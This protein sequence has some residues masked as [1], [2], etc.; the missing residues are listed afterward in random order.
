MACGLADRPCICFHPV[1]TTAHHLMLDVV[2]ENGI[3][4]LPTFLPSPSPPPNTQLR[5]SSSNLMCPLRHP[6]RLPLESHILQQLEINLLRQSPRRS[7]RLYRLAQRKLAAHK[8]ASLL[9]ELT[10]PLSPIRSPG[11]WHSAKEGI[12][13]DEIEG[14]CGAGEGCVK[15]TRSEGCGATD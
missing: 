8:N 1:L 14:G 15:V 12:V 5:P 10:H 6:P 4:I 13:V 9:D 11:W 7:L 3:S 2:T